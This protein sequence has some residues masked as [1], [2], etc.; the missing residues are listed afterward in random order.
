MYFALEILIPLW[1]DDQCEH[2]KTT[3]PFRAKSSQSP[4]EARCFGLEGLDC[5]AGMPGIHYLR[6]SMMMLRRT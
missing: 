3:V 4:E 2:V 6:T 5:A 1:Y